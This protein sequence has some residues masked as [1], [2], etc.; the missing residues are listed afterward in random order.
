MEIPYLYNL[1]V[2]GRGIHFYLYMQISGL[3]EIAGERGSATQ[4]LHCRDKVFQSTFDVVPSMWYE[5]LEEKSIYTM[6]N[7]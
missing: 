3:P 4:S 6:F 7:F 5:C 2:G 1:K